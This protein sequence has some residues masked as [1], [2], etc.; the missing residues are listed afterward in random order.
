[1]NDL[2]AAVGQAAAVFE[3]LGIPYM[4]IGGLAVSAW[5]EPRA[6]LDADFTVW[7]EPDDF[8]QTVLRLCESFQCL[9]RNPAEFTR[10]TRVLP[11]RTRQGTRMDIIFG[12]L[13]W[14]KAA[15]ARAQRKELAGRSV[16]VA[17]VED[18]IVM[19]LFSER[20]KDADDARRLLIRFKSDL[21]QGYLEPLL[22]SLADALARPEIL[23]TWRNTRDTPR[24]GMNS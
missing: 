7:T 15:I 5:G 11:V 22:R 3:S 24:S 23:E 18:L 8:E 14:E 9:T 17:S 20:E 6:T 2:E 4:L 12:A 13:P 16:A 10:G 21:D 19:K 1:M